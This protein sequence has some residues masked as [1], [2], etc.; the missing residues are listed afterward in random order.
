[1]DTESKGR[2]AADRRPPGEERKPHSLSK[3]VFEDLRQ[4]SLGGTF[5]EGLRE[6]YRFYLD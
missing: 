5:R 2:R 4:V 1:M 6:V 3:I